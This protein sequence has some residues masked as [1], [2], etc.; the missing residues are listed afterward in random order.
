MEDCQIKAGI[1]HILEGPSY[2]LL[3]FE[4]NHMFF[5]NMIAKIKAGGREYCFISDR[6]DILCN[7]KVVFSSAYHIAGEDD[8]PKYFL[9]A[10]EQ[11]IRSIQTAKTT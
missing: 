6:G 1:L 4:R 3:H 5:G 10:I 9:K 7:G 11:L 2:E 8:S